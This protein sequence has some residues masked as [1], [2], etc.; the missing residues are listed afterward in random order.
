M[1]VIHTG[2]LFLL[3][4]ASVPLILHLFSLRRPKTVEISTFRFLFDSFIQQRR[5]MRLLDALVAMLR[6]LFLLLLALVVARP[7]ASHWSALFAGGAGRD[8]L[9]LVDCSAS[10]NA[11]TGGVSSFDRES[12][13][14]KDRPAAPRRRPADALPRRGAKRGSLQPLSPRRRVDRRLDSIRSS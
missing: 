3:P 7:V 5:R 13:A 1:D 10:M 8:V 2:L 4:L 9:L 6:T 14:A 11:Q 12:G